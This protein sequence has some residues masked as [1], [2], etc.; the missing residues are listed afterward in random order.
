M[1]NGPS[2][3]KWKLTLPV[4]SNLYRLAGQLMSDLTDR[5]Y[6]YLFGKL[7]ACLP[8]NYFGEMKLIIVFTI[9]RYQVFLHCKGFEHGH[10]RRPKIRT[11]LP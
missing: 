10:S 5:N 4:I 9:C 7:I 2:Y 8:Q 6:F 3:R 11:A 1:V